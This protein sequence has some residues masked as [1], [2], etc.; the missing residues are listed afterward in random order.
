MKLT[1]VYVALLVSF[2]IGILVG[3]TIASEDT[4]EIY[5]NACAMSDVIRISIDT[6]ISVDS[7]SETYQKN[8]NAYEYDID[9]IDYSRFGWCY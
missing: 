1:L 6:G 3:H 2:L 4:K 8:M 5:Q 9:S 7:I